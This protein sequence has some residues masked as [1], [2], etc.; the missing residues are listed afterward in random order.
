[1]KKT[2]SK[3]INKINKIKKINKSSFYKTKRLLKINDINI[4]KILISKKEPYGKKGPFNG[5]AF[6]Y[7]IAYEDHDYIGS[8]CIKLPQMI[9]HV[10]CF[11][12]NKTVSFKVTGN[13]QLEKHTEIWR[14]VNNLMNIEFDNE[15]VYGDVQKYLKTKIKMCE[16]RVNTNFQ[17]KEVPKENASYD[18]LSLITLDSVF[19]VNKKYYLQTLLEECKYKIRKIEKILLMMIWRLILIVSLMMNLNAIPLK[20]SNV[21]NCVW[22]SKSC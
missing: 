6:K 2:I 22:L 21:F 9:G 13:N 14:R 4:D 16:D 8:L 10:K 7:F 15:P 17:G 20:A 18:C 11:D 12:N 1:M 3:K 5:I 19:R